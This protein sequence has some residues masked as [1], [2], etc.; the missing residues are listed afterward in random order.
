M[1]DTTWRT[2]A[3]LA[4]WLDKSNAPSDHET[5]MRLMKL[6]EETG[7]VMQAYIGYIGQ[8]PRKGVT[9]ST[10]DVAD[11]LCDVI[12]TAMV[13]LTS[14]V[15]DPEQHLATKLNKIA[16]RVGVPAGEQLT[17]NDARDREIARLRAEY[18]RLRAID[19]AVLTVMDR[20]KNAVPEAHAG[21]PVYRLLSDLAVARGLGRPPERN[22]WDGS[23]G[24]HAPMPATTDPGSHTV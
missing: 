10:F 17:N 15:D 24:G 2:I 9:H 11:E 13:A 19:A 3:G 5:A 21:H 16:A 20:A 23:T 18:D 8:N 4:A 7:E 12:V 14:F 1:T 6:S 22:G